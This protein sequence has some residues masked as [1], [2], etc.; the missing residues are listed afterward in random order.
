MESKVTNSMNV[1]RKSLQDMQI[2]DILGDCY[3]ET[4]LRYH[5]NTSRKVYCTNVET[6]FPGEKKIISV[7][8]LDGYIIQVNEVFVHMSGFSR[9][10]LIGMPHSILRHPDMPRVAFKG[11]WDALNK[12]GHWHGYVKNLRK[13]GGF[14]W[15]SASVF[16]LHRHGKVV[17]YT[18]SR[19]PAPRDQVEACTKL[20][21]ELLDQEMS[22][23]QAS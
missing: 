14:Y 16:A 12:D 20:Y 9:K 11:L 5:D 1:E 15:V 23:V 10:E 19:G 22:E 17:G 2:N 21:N 18:S 13:D 7:T 3:K 6:H 8:D 4:V